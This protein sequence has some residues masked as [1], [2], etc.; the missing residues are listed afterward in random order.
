[1]ATSRFFERF[2]LLG[3][4]NAL[5][6]EARSIDEVLEVLR[7]QAR[8]IAQADGVAVI[9]REGD[10]VVYVGED[11]ISPLWTGQ[12]FP[13]AQC[14]SG[15]AILARAP[16][17]IPDIGIDARVPLGA[18]LSTFVKSMAVFP[19]G[20]PAPTAALGLYWRD[21]RPL[22]R[23]VEALVGFLSQAANVAFE[24]IAIRSERAQGKLG[25]GS[26]AQAA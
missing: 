12:R 22:G 16:I 24:T 4:A 5:L 8:A 26:V 3:E 15:M 20:T 23:D 7:S 11:A 1:M 18:Y 13:I 21:V 9:R 25:A 14:V 19:L 6:A 2:R 10:D 17:V